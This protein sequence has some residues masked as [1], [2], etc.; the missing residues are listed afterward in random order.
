ML[1]FFSRQDV[2]AQIIYVFICQLEDI[3]SVVEH[4]TQLVQNS[5]L[6]LFMSPIVFKLVLYVTMPAVFSQTLST[7][8]LTLFLSSAL[9]HS[10]SS[11]SN[12][13]TSLSLS[14]DYNLSLSYYHWVSLYILHA[15]TIFTA[16]IH[17]RKLINYLSFCGT[18][19]SR[20][21]SLTLTG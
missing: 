8:I 10:L 7:Q 9:T 1:F 18:F 12:R 21:V 4:K 6:L 11:N 2:T 19:V 17:H 15:M 13:P 14:Y 16:E 20:L 3:C 5:S